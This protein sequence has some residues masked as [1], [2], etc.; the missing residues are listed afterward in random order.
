MSI[1]ASHSNSM[2]VYFWQKSPP[3]PGNAQC[4]PF[5]MHDRN[6]DREVCSPWDLQQ[7]NRFSYNPMGC[8]NA[9]PKECETEEYSIRSVSSAFDAQAVSG[10]LGGNIGKVELEWFM[11]THSIIHVAFEKFG[12]T[13][14]IQYFPL[15]LGTLMSNVGGLLGLLLGGSVLTLVHALMFLLQRLLT[16]ASCRSGSNRASIVRATKNAENQL[17]MGP[18]PV[19]LGLPSSLIEAESSA[20]AASIE[21]EIV[22]EMP[23]NAESADFRNQ[24]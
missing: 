10:F 11:S 21:E 18:N 20:A 8:F 6:K 19:G 22:S 5:G 3:P 17:H 16:A 1:F 9:C 7:S 15:T 4:Q 24:I 13:E 12:Y 23:T 2:H 14:V